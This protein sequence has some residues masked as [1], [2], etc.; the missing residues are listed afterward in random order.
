MEFLPLGRRRSSARNVP[1]GERGETDVFAGYEWASIHFTAATSFRNKAP[2]NS[3]FYLRSL[4]I[5]LLVFKFT[6]SLIFYPAVMPYRKNDFVDAVNRCHSL[7][8]Y[9]L[10][11]SFT[12]LV[13]TMNY[14]TFF[15][16]LNES[17]S[18]DEDGE[19]SALSAANQSLFAI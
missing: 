10:R 7:C 5:S 2:T 3:P 14:V 8:F 18:A 17:A 9:F 19:T 11:I 12:C 13:F 4:T 6:T 15:S 1:S 16:R